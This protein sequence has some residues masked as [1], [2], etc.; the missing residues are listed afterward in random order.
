MAQVKKGTTLKTVWLVV[1]VVG[2]VVCLVGAGLAERVADALRRK[3]VAS[4][5][6]LT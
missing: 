2:A 1:C 4:K 6:T 3:K 5:N